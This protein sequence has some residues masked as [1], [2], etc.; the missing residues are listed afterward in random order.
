M[1]SACVTWREMGSTSSTPN[2]GVGSNQEMLRS[3]CF[4][5]RYNAFRSLGIKSHSNVAT[6]N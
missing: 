4:H 3:V 1:S 6:L 2:V 5:N